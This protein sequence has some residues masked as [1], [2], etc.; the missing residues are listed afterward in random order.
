MLI[1]GYVIYY[2]LPSD[3][4]FFTERRS[5]DRGYF[6]DYGDTPVFWENLRFANNEVSYFI[7]PSCPESRK[8]SMIEAFDIFSQEM[9][10][11]S[12]FVF[13]LY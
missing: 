9:I 13:L 11:V 7:E 1:F 12:F 2:N 5:D 10:V 3:P 6:I 4:I 8:K